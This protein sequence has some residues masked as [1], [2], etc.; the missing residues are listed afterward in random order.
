MIHSLSFKE[1]STHMKARGVREDDV[2]EALSFFH[3]LGDLYWLNE[4]GLRDIVVL[5]P[6]EYFVRPIRLIICDPLLHTKG[7]TH[8][9]CDR[10]SIPYVE[11]KKG[12]LRRSLLNELLEKWKDSVD[13]IVLLMLKLGL[14]T[15]ISDDIYLVPSLLELS[16][17]HI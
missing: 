17:I 15:K 13:K 1:A 8:E 3:Q 2:E 4:V 14:M 12:K 10:D 9:T 11:Y 7:T 5:D 6:F 16:L